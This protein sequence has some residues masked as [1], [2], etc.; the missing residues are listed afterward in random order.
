[1]TTELVRMQFKK[2]CKAINKVNSTE[3]ITNAQI[4][5][6]NNTRALVD[7]KK[8][9]AQDFY[10]TLEKEGIYPLIIESGVVY[11]LSVKLFEVNKPLFE[12]VEL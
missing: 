7:V 5:E 9:V 4:V 6:V 2:V 3:G 10:N 8:E 12:V 11:T 1:M